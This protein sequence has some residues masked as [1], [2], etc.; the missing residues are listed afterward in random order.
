MI[1]RFMQRFHAVQKIYSP[2]HALYYFLRTFTLVGL[3]LGNM[4]NFMATVTATWRYLKYL[5]QKSFRSR[6]KKVVKKDAAGKKIVVQQARS[7]SPVWGKTDHNYLSDEQM[8]EYVNRIGELAVR[9]RLIH[10]DQLKEALARQAQDKSK[11]LGDILVEM[12][13]IDEVGFAML[14]ST[15]LSMP[16]QEIDPFRIDHRVLRLIPEEL[17]QNHQIVP[18]AIDDAENLI[19]ASASPLSSEDYEI[20]ERKT[21]HKIKSVITYQSD[22][23]FSR[24]RAYGMAFGAEASHVPQIGF[25]LLTRGVINEDQLS[26]AMHEQSLNYRPLGEILV[27]NGYITSSDLRALLSEQQQ[28]RRQ[29]GEVLLSEGRISNVQL[30]EALLR[31]KKESRPLGEILLEM[32]AVTE[33]DLDDYFRHHIGLGFKLVRPVDI[34]LEL[35]QE[36]PRA[37]CLIH[38][39][40]PLDRVDGGLRIAVSSVAR[41][42]MAEMLENR[43]GMK[44]EMIL[45]SED[46][47]LKAISTCCPLINE[48]I[49]GSRLL[50]NRL[51]AAGVINGGQLKAALEIQKASGLRLGEVLINNSYCTEEALLEIYADDLYLPFVRLSRDNIDPDAGRMYPYS[52]AREHGIAPL[53]YYNNI[54]TCALPFNFNFEDLRLLET[55]FPMMKVNYVMATRDDIDE[56]IR[57]LYFKQVA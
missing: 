13:L 11:R 37:F 38:R 46:S 44:V 1:E 47:I 8:R 51:V 48:A 6:T 4:I 55:R 16:S 54:L 50:G 25:T 43:F 49:A 27:N 39:A 20:L 42:A 18:L 26:E 41:K 56:T 30:N 10:G 32:K 34:D 15:Q 3:L 45:S 21:G 2:K 40:I 12:N 29:L 17:A 7:A 53:N 57:L 31:Q 52:E 36:F 33:T 9:S 22:V 24:R 28:K 23:D 35:L 5:W 19:V 14:Y